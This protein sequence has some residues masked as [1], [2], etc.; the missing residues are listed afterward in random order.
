MGPR[1][2]FLCIQKCFINVSPEEIPS[3]FFVLYS[4]I[5]RTKPQATIIYAL[6]FKLS[7][8]PLN[9]TARTFAS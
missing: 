8:F 1:S 9:T 6:F 3:L 7:S 2:H 5:L 4:L